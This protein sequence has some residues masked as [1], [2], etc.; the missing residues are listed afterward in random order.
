MLYENEFVRVERETSQV[1]WIK[2]FTREPYK[3]LTDCPDE[4]RAHLYACMEAAE[5]VMRSYYAPDKINIAMFGNYLP[6]LHIHVIARFKDDDYFPESM[7]GVKQRESTTL[8]LP[9]FEGFAARLID[10]LKSCTPE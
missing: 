8:K 5:R 4:L 6:R 7:W 2:I 1:P 3:E 9:D 10:E